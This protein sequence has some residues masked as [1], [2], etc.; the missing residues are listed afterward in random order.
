MLESKISKIYDIIQEKWIRKNSFFIFLNY[1]DENLE[2]FFRE[3][4]NQKTFENLFFRQFFMILKH[5]KK[6]QFLQSFLNLLKYKKQ[7]IDLAE[8][9]HFELFIRDF[10]TSEQI[11]RIEIFDLFLKHYEKYKNLLEN[12]N[13]ENWILKL[14][15]IPL[16]Q[17][18]DWENFLTFNLVFQIFDKNL[19]TSDCS[20]WFTCSIYF[21]DEESYG[22]SFF[23]WNDKILVS[24]IQWFY[25]LKDS[26]NLMKFN[27]IL[28][29]TILE[30]SKK[31]NKNILGFSNKN[32]PCRFHTVGKGFCWDYDNIFESIWMEKMDENYY[33][34]KFE[35]LKVKN[36]NEIIK[37]NVEYNLKNITKYFY[38]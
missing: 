1:I 38:G 9:Y 18:F 8:K 5:N 4:L 25:S 2:N 32:H 11:F 23:I 34:W 31:L 33:F 14:E 12:K 26:S 22:I 7:I 36:M 20:N 30:I 6:E 10:Q 19:D 28:L 17:I 29:F 35:K 15:K 37:A 16:F 13:F 21:E 24:S 3:N 27:K